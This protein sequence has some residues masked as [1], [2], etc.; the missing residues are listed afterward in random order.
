[1]KAI[2]LVD[3]GS[4]KS[5]TLADIHDYLQCIYSDAFILPEFAGQ[6]PRYE[7][8]QATMSS[9]VCTDSSSVLDP[10]TD[11]IQ[12]QWHCPATYAYR[13]G[14]PSIA[15][16]IQHLLQETNGQLDHLHVIPMFP[17]RTAVASQAIQTAI[18]HYIQAF[19][20]P[21]SISVQKPYIATQAYQQAIAGQLQAYD[22]STPIV[23][24]FHGASTDLIK[25]MDPSRITCLSKPNCCE[26][27]TP[28][29]DG[30]FRR[31]AY[32]LC[33]AISPRVYP[34][35]LD[36]LFMESDAK[37]TP[38]RDPFNSIQHSDSVRF[39]PGW[40]TPSIIQQL[41]SHYL[42]TWIQ[43]KSPATSTHLPNWSEAMHYQVILSSIGLNP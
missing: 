17:Q 23:A 25:K 5:T 7:L 16:G 33:Q 10:V 36:Q 35:F 34:V 43:P 18:Q 37:H 19:K 39:L 29:S 24:G 8:N 32:A 22:A 11:A 4:P 9:I 30:C 6:Q 3:L 28:V 21:V 13:Y 31:Q 20:I 26:N 12:T 2:L 38:S 14:E 41:D 42:A 27:P 1:M 40:M 15:S